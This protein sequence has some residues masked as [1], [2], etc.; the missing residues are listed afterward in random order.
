MTDADAT[1]EFD[2][3]ATIDPVGPVASAT[4]EA[5]SPL[6]VACGTPAF[7]GDKFC[8]SCGE[9]LP[10]SED[11][12]GGDVRANSN[13]ADVAGLDDSARMIG[14]Q[15]DHLS[16][17][18]CGGTYDDG[19][20]TTCGAKQP[21]LRDHLER[22]IPGAAGVTDRGRHHR[23]NEDAMALRRD[24]DVVAV[25]IGDGVST[26]VDPD[27]ASEAAVE[28]ALHHLLTGAD[29]ITAHRAAQDAAAALD[30]VPH[31]RLGS[32][33][34]TYLA[35]R[36]T[37]LDVEIASLGDCRAYWITPDATTLVTTDDSWAHEQVASGAMTE[38]EAMADR[39]A[40]VIT[41]WL[42]PDADPAWEPTV[43]SF[44]A[45]GPGRLVLS[46]DG[47]WNYAPEPADLLAATPDTDLREAPLLDVAQE[48]VAFANASGG[49]DNITVVVIDVPSSATPRD[50]PGNVVAAHHPPHATTPE[51][52]DDSRS[53]T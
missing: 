52:E 4:R 11:P 25:V 39:R 10:V 17:I 12:A 23:R 30:Y 13:M 22:S 16:C 24:G 44:T 21:A 33:S 37:G 47:L 6:C 29:H 27:R 38:A 14:E 36:V 18:S 42:G 9:N 28:A 5:T 41:R 15:P 20:C 35:A 45:S 51:R 31:A 1:Q 49:R 50:E 53:P 40:H 8:E 34:T 46:S 2:V 43:Q 7:P 19:W 26:T 32:P 3:P 48:L